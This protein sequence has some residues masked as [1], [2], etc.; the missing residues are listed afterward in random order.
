MTV[1]KMLG[2]IAVLAMGLH[3]YATS[4]PSPH[5][6]RNNT[7]AASIVMLSAEWCGY[8]KAL[9]NDLDDMGV[10]YTELDIDE[11]EGGRA[12]FRAVKARGVPVLVVGQEVVYGYDPGRSRALIEAAGHPLAS[13]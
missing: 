5:D 13:R 11:D 4:G 9:R 2:V 7:G 3:L 1:Q 10:A 6:P 12:A 8:C